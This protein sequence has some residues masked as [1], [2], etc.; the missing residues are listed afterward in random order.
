[1]SKKYTLTV[2][3]AAPGTPLTDNK[4][5][6][7]IDSKSGKQDHSVVGHIYYKISDGTED[8][9]KGYGFAPEKDG[10][11]FGPG[12][13]QEKEY[14]KYQNP[15]YERQL[16]ISEA[17]YKKLLDYGKT[18]HVGGFDDKTYNGLN[19]SCID[20]VYGGLAYAG[21]YNPPKEKIRVLNKTLFEKNYEGTVTVRPNA[22]EFD[23]IPY[24][25]GNERNPLNTPPEQ[26]RHENP[27]CF[28]AFGFSWKTGACLLSENR[29]Q[30]LNPGQP[31]Y[32][33]MQNGQ[34][35][36]QTAPAADKF[37]LLAQTNHLIAQLQ[38]GNPRAL[39]EFTA[40][41][42]IQAAAQAS[43]EEAQMLLRENPHLADGLLPNRFNRP[44]FSDMPP[45][46]QKLY[47]EGKEKLQGYYQEHGIRY[48]EEAL[49][50]TAMALA[51]EGYRNRMRSVTMIVLKDGQVH[52]G[53]DT[54]PDFRRASVDA[55][56]AG[57]TAGHESM[58]R[59]QETEQEFARQAQQREMER[60]AESRSRGMSIG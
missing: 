6:P 8:G 52:I 41:P 1:M 12:K 45:Q 58:A 40:Q 2:Y 27:S 13:V 18:P 37:D 23:K 59:A 46:V 51:A 20:F 25:I 16:E 28:K 53:D 5:Q 17:Q 49:E 31:Q 36:I 60:M 4:G 56:E 19:N 38:A 9:T 44:E 24:Q 21:V 42:E 22:D 55:K 14:E 50:N 15:V 35:G 43:R 33:H 30:D 39:A 26:R 10:D 7:L 48:G 34:P 3:I 57:L 11:A 29:Q 32:A 47:A 54:A